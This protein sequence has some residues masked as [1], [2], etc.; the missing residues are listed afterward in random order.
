VTSELFALGQTER[1]QRFTWSPS[2]LLLTPAGTLQG[3]AALGAAAIAMEAV[4]SRPVVWAT[5]QYM[6]F[7][8]G[9]DPLDLDVAIEVAGRN[10]S[11]ARCV[12]SRG[13]VQILTAVAALGRRKLDVE[14]TWRAPPAVPA[15][16]D[17]P[18]YRFFEYGRGHVGDLAELRLARG[19]QLH[20]IDLRGGRGDG[21]FAVWIRCW[22]GEHDVTVSDLAF[23]GDFM[24]VGFA[25]AIGAPF[26]GNS[27]DNT[28]RVGRLTTTGWVLLATHVEQVV[29]GFGHGRA[30]LWAEDGTL[31]GSVSQT[32]VM[33][34]HSRIRRPGA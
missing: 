31:L 14:G 32:A 28:I 26:A 13:D 4:V 23:I 12:V 19:R 6:T 7:A 5:A 20:D 9:H 27:L 1:P 22:D 34:L 17:C 21:S 8:A 10:T 16:D 15:P 29:N 30:E 2:Q 33:R 3:G 11:Q 18:R 25:D 24:P